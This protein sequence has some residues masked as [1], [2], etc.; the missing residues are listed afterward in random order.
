MES[1][2]VCNNG[3]YRLYFSLETDA[4]FTVEAADEKTALLRFDAGVKQ[5]EV[6]IGLSSIDEASAAGER[7]A[8]VPQRFD[9]LRK[10]AA[11]AWK[12]ILSPCQSPASGRTSHEVATPAPHS[13]TD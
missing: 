10:E 12:Q 7:A 9:A 6:R 2:T 13:L 3:L 4:P 5:V 11:R 1:S 8:V